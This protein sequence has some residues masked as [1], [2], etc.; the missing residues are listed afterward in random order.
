MHNW[1]EYVEQNKPLLGLWIAITDP[2][3]IELAKL[4]GFDYVRLDNEYIPFDYGK[5]CE[6]IRTANLLDIPIHIR[7][8][9][10]ED[11]TSFVSFGADGIIVPDCD[12]VERAKKAIE[13]TKFWPVGARGMNPAGRSF[14]KAGVPPAEYLQKA[15]DCIALTVQIEDANVADRIDDILSLEGIDMVA[16]GRADISQSLG[17]PGQITHPKVLEFEDLVIRKALEHGK[18]PAILALTKEDLTNLIGKGAKVF[19]LANDEGL[20]FTAMKEKVAAFRKP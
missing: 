20:L 1:K 7:I 16:S 8:S 12:T 6:M 19:T 14:R 4:A 18:I 5:I 9:R 15:N 13:L 17:I 11:I 2:G 10:M 3:V